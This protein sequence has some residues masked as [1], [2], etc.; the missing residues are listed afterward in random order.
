MFRKALRSLKPQMSNDQ[1]SDGKS[2]T[3]FAEIKGRRGFPESEGAIVTL[4][5]QLGNTQLV[6]RIWT[7]SFLSCNCAATVVLEQKEQRRRYALSLSLKKKK[8]NRN[9]AP[10]LTSACRTIS[11]YPG[12]LHLDR[13]TVH[14]LKQAKILRC[15]DVCF[16]SLNELVN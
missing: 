4:Y 1:I 5:R 16:S 2:A 15:L 10:V 7:L 12:S 9:G 3:D 11:P 14:E 8:K 13:V 6:P